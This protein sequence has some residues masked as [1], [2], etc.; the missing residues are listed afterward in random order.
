MRL[1]H[2]NI[3][4]MRE[5]FET[6]SELMIVMEMATGGELFE[7]IYLHSHGIVH[8]DLKP[9]NLLYESDNDG[10]LL[11]VADFGMSEMM[12]NGKYSIQCGASGYCAPEVIL[13]KDYGP[14]VDIWNLGVIIYIILCGLEPFWDDAGDAAVQEKVIKADYSFDT[15]GWDGVSDSAKDLISKLLQIDPAK[16]LT[17]KEALNHPWV[18]GETTGQ[19]HL[20]DTQKRLREIHARRKFRAATHAVLATRRALALLSVNGSPKLGKNSKFQVKSEDQNLAKSA[21]QEN[22]KAGD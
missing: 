13:K 9:E 21:S 8:R 7:R 14:P 10:A 16:R 3:V 11:K 2:P 18:C 15:D 1:R 4:Q 17:A 22:K 20:E 6:D 12:V 19:E 5:A